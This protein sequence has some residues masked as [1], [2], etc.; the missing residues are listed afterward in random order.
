[1]YQPFQLNVYSW[2]NSL[3]PPPLTLKKKK[4]NKNKNKQKNSVALSLQANYTDWATGTRWR[5]LV[6]GIEPRTSELAAR[7]PKALNKTEIEST[8]FYWEIC[9]SN[10]I[11]RLI[12][13][14]YYNK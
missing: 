2:I 10:M 5:N 3:G 8:D 7:D 12:T 9:F 14:I 4:E 13:F 11:K 6:P 1:M